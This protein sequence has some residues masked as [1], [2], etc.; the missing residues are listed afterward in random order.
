MGTYFMYFSILQSLN[1]LFLS[2]IESLV[3]DVHKPSK[4]IHL[5]AKAQRHPKHIYIRQ[6]HHNALHIIWWNKVTMKLE[7]DSVQKQNETKQPCTRI[8]NDIESQKKKYACT[9]HG[10]DKM[11]KYWWWRRIDDCNCIFFIFFASI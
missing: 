8:L 5:H 11:I 3:Y 6:Q 7:Y 2:E 10:N 4:I 9:R 1:K